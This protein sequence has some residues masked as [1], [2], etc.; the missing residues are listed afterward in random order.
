MPSLLKAIVTDDLVTDQSKW[1]YAEDSDATLRNG[2]C[3]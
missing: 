2:E 1:V 3:A